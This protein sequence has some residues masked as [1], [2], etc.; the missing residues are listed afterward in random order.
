MTESRWLKIVTDKETIDL[1]E[2]LPGLIFLDT[3]QEYPV[4][5]DSKVVI[6]GLDGELPG[7]ISFA[8][9]NLILRFGVDGHDTEDVYL[10]EQKLRNLFFKRNYYFVITSDLPNKKFAVSNPTI[11]P[12][13]KDSS[14]IE[15]EVTFQVYKGYSESLYLTDQFSLG[16]GKWQFE[17][18]LVPDSDIKYKHTRTL[19]EIF[20]G[21]SDTIDP[22]H[23]HDLKIRIR[24]ATETGFKIVN[25]ETGDVFE[26]TGKLKANQSFLIDGGYVYKD[27][28]RCGRQ[29]N[30]GILRLAPGY[31]TF[32]VW[33]KISNFEIEFVFPFIYR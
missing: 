10:A 28:K 31:N 1:E 11:T 6:N 4:L 15:L 9:F 16:D 8:P 13:V 22:R 27:E 14:S 25:K 21:S 29:T 33:G 12:T 24:L 3:K 18:G 2:Q 26:Y 20:N 19:F 30:H 17:N 32:E 23:S 5:Y 7:A